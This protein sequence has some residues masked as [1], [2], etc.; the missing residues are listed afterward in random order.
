MTDRIRG[1]GRSPR[2]SSRGLIWKNLSG[3][4]IPPYACVKLRAYVAADDYFEAVKPDGDGSLHFV[5]G[6][7]PV[8]A[9]AYG[10]SMTWDIS[11]LGLTDG[12]FGETVGPT[13]DSW[14]MTTGGTGWTVFSVPENGF[15]A[16]LR[17]GGSGGGGAHWIEFTVVDVYCPGDNDYDDDIGKGRLYVD[18][19]VNWY[20]GGCSTD[21]PGYNSYFGLVRIFD[22]CRGIF[23]FFTRDQLLGESPPYIEPMSGDAVYLYPFGADDCVPEW[24]VKAVCGVPSC[25]D[26]VSPPLPEEEE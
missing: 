4:T 21:P 8:L 10:G 11:R 5:N 26:S 16:L 1:P 24:H 9:N 22:S 13:A 20:T 12:A 23:K 15:A 25:G 17:D 6:P 2:D 7:V 18:A 19:E 14:E 3:E